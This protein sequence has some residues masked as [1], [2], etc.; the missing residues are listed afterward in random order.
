VELWELKLY[1]IYGFCIKR[2]AKI[3]TNGSELKVV[4]LNALLLD[5]DTD[6]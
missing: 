3:I 5:A 6:Y 2:T 1:A 4:F